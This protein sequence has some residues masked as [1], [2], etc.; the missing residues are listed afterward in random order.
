VSYASIDDLR[1]QLGAKASSSVRSAAYAAKMLHELPDA[2]TR[3]RAAF[4]LDRVRG[5]RVL[6]FGASGPMHD[7]V[8]Q[9]AETCV[10]V[11]RA[12]SA[13][14]VAFD[15]DDVRQLSLPVMATPDVVLCGEVL[16]HLSNPGWFLARLKGQYPGVPVL[17]TVPNAFSHVARARLADGVENVNRDHVCWYS[18]TTLRTLL[19][20]AGYTVRECYYYGGHGPTA[21]GLIVVAD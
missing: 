15:L 20:R 1:S 8:A 12:A 17:L 21:Q 3:D 16:E 6:E 13:D 11:D 9:A 18:V 5:R 10:G 14:V 4:I 19:A 2:E 7:A